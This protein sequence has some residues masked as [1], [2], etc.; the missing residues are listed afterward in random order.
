VVGDAVADSGRPVAIEG[1]RAL[2]VEM[3]RRLVAVEVLEHG[4]Q[5]LAAVENLRRLS[6]RALHVHDEV[7]VLTEERLLALGIAAIRA[8]RVGVNE[9]AD[10]EAVSLLDR[11]DLG[12]DSRSL[13][14]RHLTGVG[15]MAEFVGEPWV[16]WLPV[17]LGPSLGRL[18]ALIEQQDCGEIVAQAGASLIIRTR[19]CSRSTDRDGC[20]LGEFGHGLV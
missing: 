11:C 15:T 16:G 14:G 7:R 6:T 4:R 17:E 12:V 1:D 18:G 8:I 2:T 9:L 5:R 3:H 19:D 10:R 20:R 13:A